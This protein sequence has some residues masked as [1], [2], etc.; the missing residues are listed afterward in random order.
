MA[1]PASVNAGDDATAAQYN[2]AI[3][4]TEDVLTEDQTLAGVKTFSGTVKVAQDIQHDGDVDTKIAFT[5]DAIDQRTGGSSRL[6]LSDSGVRLGAANA[7][8]TTVL[9]E[10][11]M[12]SDSATVLCTQQSIKA[13]GDTKFS[14]VV[15]KT[16]KTS[17]G[18]GNAV[19][20]TDID[21]TAATSAN[22]TGVFLHLSSVGGA[23]TIWLRKNG[24]TD[25]SGSVQV[26]VA[27]GADQYGIF[28]GVDAG[29]IFEYR[30]AGG[31]ATV[32]FSVIGYTEDQ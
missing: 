26:D 10:D 31:T 5:A 17:V 4:Y 27:N 13:Y 7:R 30:T 12:G 9:D 6:D 1:K 21:C 11:A 19:N 14:K 22:A 23:D 24:S 3:D 29:E 8:V 20:F 18:G 2:N 32:T 25:A 15:W 28:I 16:N